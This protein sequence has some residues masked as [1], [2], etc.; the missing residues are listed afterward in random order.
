VCTERERNCVLMPCR[1]MICE[2]CAAR[3]SGGGGGARCP[4]CRAA[5]SNTIVG[6]G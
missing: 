3:I 2:T 6:Y 5:I 1:H 4:L